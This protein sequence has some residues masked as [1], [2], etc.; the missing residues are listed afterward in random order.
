MRDDRVKP[1]DTDLDLRA[2]NPEKLVFQSKMNTL[3]IGLQFALQTGLFLLFV[4]AEFFS[5][6]GMLPQ[7][8]HFE[9]TPASLN[10]VGMASFPLLIT[11]WIFY[12][13]PGSFVKD[14]RSNM[15]VF[16]LSLLG[17]QT[18]L[19]QAV[20]TTL[21][22]SFITGNPSLAYQYSVDKTKD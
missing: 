3:V 17:L 2:I 14:M 7:L 22:L 9:I 1:A 21:I 19:L 8:G 20:F 12:N 13:L 16:S 10:L 4:V 5:Q 15:K 18:P 6:F 11:G